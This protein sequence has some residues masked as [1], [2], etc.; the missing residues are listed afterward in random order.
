MQA[1]GQE[2]NAEVYATCRAAMLMRGQESGNIRFGDTLVRDGLPTLEADYLLCNP[3]AGLDWSKA[4]ETVRAEHERGHAGRFGPGLPRKNDGSLLFLL[5]MLSKM[6]PVLS[7]GSRL[8]VVTAGS[9][10][11]TGAAGSGESEIRQW[12]IEND[13]LEA[14]VVLPVGMFR[15]TA[16]PMYVWL[17]TNRKAAHRRGKVQLID[18]GDNYRRRHRKMDSKS[19]EFSEDNVGAVVSLLRGQDDHPAVAWLK[20]EE[21]GYRRL[22]LGR[23]LRLNFRASS[24]R[25]ARVEDERA[26]QRLVKTKENGQAAQTKIEAGRALQAAVLGVLKAMDGARLYK[27]R[28]EFEA[29]LAAEAKVQGVIIPK[30]I[31]RAIRNALSERDETAEVAR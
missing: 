3:P 18:A 11:F 29:S 19:R 13:W 15:H 14:I 5:H 9:P 30:A 26:W 8:A 31:Q 24:E 21:L 28:P 22:T 27:S 1:Y 12:I 16:S 25:I 17:I 2:L 23:S 10:L 6:K 7:G 4:A 20:N